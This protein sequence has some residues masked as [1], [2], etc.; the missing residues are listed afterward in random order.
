MNNITAT[1]LIVASIGLFFGYINPT[2]GSVTGSAVL[3]EKS[4]QE[5]QKDVA[6]YTDALS[7]AHEIEKVRTGLLEVYNS[8]PADD[9]DKLMKLLPDHIDSVR[10][11]IDINNVAAQF[12]MTLKNITLAGDGKDTPKPASSAIGPKDTT[13]SSVILQF[14]VSGSYGDFRLFL[15]D[16]EKSLRLIDVE[17]LGFASKVDTEAYEYRVTIATYRLE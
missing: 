16:L 3:T 4:I 15:A 17:T 11:I 1:L 14:T 9:L 6:D 2:Y 13:Y 7:K 8:I 5:L 10:L 12:G